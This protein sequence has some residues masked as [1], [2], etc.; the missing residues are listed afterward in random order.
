MFSALMDGWNQWAK[1]GSGSGSSRTRQA[2]AREA[3]RAVLD[4]LSLMKD[5][6]GSDPGLAPNE[7]TYTSVLGALARSREASSG[8][9]AEKILDEMRE[10]G[11]EPAAAHWNAAMDAYAKSPRPGKL[12]EVRALWGKMTVASAS[13][14]VITYNTVLSA[15]ASASFQHQQKAGRRDGQESLARQQRECLQVGLSAFASLQ[16][17]PGVRAT[18][19][20][21]HYLF[22]LLRNCCSEEGEAADEETAPP[23]PPR[24]RLV[25]RAI[26]LCC[27][28]G[29]LNDRI[30]EQLARDYG[31]SPE[32]LLGSQDSIGAEAEDGETSRMIRAIFRLGDDGAPVPSS[33]PGRETTAAAAAARASDL[34]REWSA[35]SLPV[36]R[37][38]Q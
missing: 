35:R 27:Q 11:I 6:G 30:L 20:T 33:L 13:P 25:R 1:R 26:R 22:Q 37:R 4:L 29:C 7:R 31:S 5:L 3:S 8:P 36:L 16:R 23:T 17:D 38:R 28:D 32:L 21:Y 12:R 14:D 34:P 19:L 15:A 24:V 18:S 10:G 2:A 9:R